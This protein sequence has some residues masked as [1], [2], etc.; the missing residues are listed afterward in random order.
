MGIDMQGYRRW[1][2]A[3]IRVIFVTCHFEMHLARMRLT[4][5]PLYTLD[6][7]MIERPYVENIDDINAR[8]QIRLKHIIYLCGQLLV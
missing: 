6:I 1:M 7:M 2:E 8:D 4:L 5:A 3:Y